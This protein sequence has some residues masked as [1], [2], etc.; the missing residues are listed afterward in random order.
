MTG[1]DYDIRLM[2]A[3]RR[4]IRA[5]DLHSKSLKQRADFTTPQLVCLT[6]L[7]QKGPLTLKALS[8]SIDLSPSTV[9]GIVDRLHAKGLVERRRGDRDRRQVMLSITDAGQGA[10]LSAPYPL[11]HT[12]LEGFH[13]LSELEQSTLTLA[14]ERVVELLGARNLDA[15]AILDVAPLPE[16]RQPASEEPLAG[17]DTPDD[18]R[19]VQLHAAGFDQPGGET[20]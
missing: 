2:R 16:T 20:A 6:A 7:A 10:L 8:E 14:M 4:V 11:Q 12:L 17:T 1:P 13:G 3:I 18:L 19:V 5:V 9:L 15:A